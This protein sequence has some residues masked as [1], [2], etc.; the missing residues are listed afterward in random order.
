MRNH[1]P[2]KIVIPP[3]ALVVPL[4]C[5]SM[6][7]LWIGSVEGQ[8]QDRR[9]RRREER[10]QREGANSNVARPSEERKRPDPAPSTNAP[11]LTTTNAAGT[12]ITSIVEAPATNAPAIL[13]GTN[14][15]SLEAFRIIPERNIFN[16][17]RTARSARSDQPAEK[18]VKVETVALLGTMSYEK[19][20]FAVFDGTSGSFKKV[21]PAGESIAG[22]KITDIEHNFVK[23]EKDGKSTQLAVGQQLKRED[24]GEWSVSAVAGPFQSGSSTSA[25]GSTNGASSSSSGGEENDVLKRLLQKREQ[26]L[27]K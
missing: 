15:Y 18:V 19:G 27:K 12:N 13:I 17:S 14:R 11:A 21:A 3:G 20:R 7:V 22:F 6:I 24:E 25:T 16:A 23:L 26:E 9:N 1:R 8:E 10:R 5:L 2:G 4:L